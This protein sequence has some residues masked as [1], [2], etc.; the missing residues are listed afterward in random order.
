MFLECNEKRIILLRY[1]LPIC[2]ELLNANIRE[3]ML[4]ELHEH[5][6]GDGGDMSTGQSGFDNMRGVP[7]AG[8]DHFCIVPV[9]FVNGDD[10]TD[11]IHAK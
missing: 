2:Q 10:L 11:E 4:D 9:V 8:N 3:G 5:L 7:D 1:L 6:V